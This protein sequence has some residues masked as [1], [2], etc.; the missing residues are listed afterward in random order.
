MKKIDY[1]KVMVDG[2]ARYAVK[3]VIA[4]DNYEGKASE[5]VREINATVEHF[6]DEPNVV[7]NDQASDWFE[8]APLELHGERWATDA[9]VEKINKAI[10]RER[11]LKKA[12]A[13]QKRAKELAELARL[14]KKYAK[15]GVLTEAS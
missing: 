7:H 14:S 9:E 1:R 5:L 10:A 3:H 6:I 11:E 8:G 13:D 15:D 12:A 2:K 4:L